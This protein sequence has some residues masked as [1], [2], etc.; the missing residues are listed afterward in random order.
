[1]KISFQ[2]HL[3]NL[4]FLNLRSIFFQNFLLLFFAKENRNFSLTFWIF[5]GQNITWS[6]EQVA[7]P[8]TIKIITAIFFTISNESTPT[9]LQKNNIKKVVVDFSK[10]GELDILVAL[11]GDDLKIGSPFRTGN[12]TFFFH[13]VRISFRAKLSF[14]LLAPPKPRSY[15]N[16]RGERWVTR[17]SSINVFAEID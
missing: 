6:P 4:V 12:E 11:A 2:F 9:S 15:V 13:L 14:A 8:G 17:T 1:M 3:N 10:G 7:K 5:A 16:F